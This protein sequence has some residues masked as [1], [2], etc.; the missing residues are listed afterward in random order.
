MPKITVKDLSVTYTA[1]TGEKKIALDGVNLE[2]PNGKLTVL[3]GENGCGKTTFMKAIAGVTEYSGAI[4][5]DGADAKHQPL[6]RRNESF[7]FQ[8]YVLYPHL[9]IFDNIALPLKEQKLQR[10]E[11]AERVHSTAKSFGIEFL[12]TRKPKQLS[13][14]QQQLAAIAKALA[15]RPTLCF[16]DEPLSNLDAATQSKMRQRIKEAV[17][18]G[19]CTAVYITHSLAEAMSLADY[20]VVLRNGKAE[21]SGAPREVYGSENALIS[22]MKAEAEQTW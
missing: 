11:I 2:I 18:E 17:K 16:F 5:F 4:L 10:A 19:A 12:L 20:I 22:A 1:R 14:G 6:A 7:V 15:K 8:N 3:L 9:T 21:L 13:G